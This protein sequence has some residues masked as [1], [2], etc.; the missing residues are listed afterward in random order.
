MGTSYSS[1]STTNVSNDITVNPSTTVTTTFDELANAL[2]SIS[3]ETLAQNKMIQTQQGLIEVAKINQQSAIQET[4]NENTL[5]WQKIIG[6]GVFGF[7]F[8]QVM[9]GK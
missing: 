1:S 4:T 3:N 5:K 2:K 6:W 7:M 8:L 9:K